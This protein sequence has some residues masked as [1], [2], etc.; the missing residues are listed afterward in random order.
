LKV[1]FNFTR[2]LPVIASIAAH[3]VLF[4]VLSRHGL[5]AHASKGPVTIDIVKSPVAPTAPPSVEPPRAAARSAIPVIRPR[6]AAPETPTPVREAPAAQPMAVASVE[7]DG[8]AGEGD[9]V[10]PAVEPGTPTG[11]GAPALPRPA[12]PVL[13]PTG[14]GTGTVDLSGY[15]SAIG[16]KVA[17]HRHYPEIAQQMGYEGICEVLLKVRKDGTL[18]GPPLVGHSSGHG[19][20]D[21]EAMRM[22]ARAAPFPAL[23][24]GYA[25]AV[26]ELRVPV[27][28]HLEN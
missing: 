17:R 7:S 27:R 22:V 5:P 19:I 13:P 4:V 1:V 8:P 14:G 6:R 25:G 26:A 3:G 24:G 12:A 15:V 11:T 9:V 23:P 20:L 16:G 21:E 10:V 18:A 28:F 2:K